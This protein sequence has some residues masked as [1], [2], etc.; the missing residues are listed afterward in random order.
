MEI[1]LVCQMNKT[2]ADI[3]NRRIYSALRITTGLDTSKVLGQVSNSAFSETQDS[4]WGT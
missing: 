3:R 2:S 1:Y 4:T